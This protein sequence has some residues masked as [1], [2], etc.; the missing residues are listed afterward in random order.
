MLSVF[1]PC[2]EQSHASVTYTNAVAFGYAGYGNKPIAIPLILSVHLSFQLSEEGEESTLTTRHSFIQM[3]KL[4][5]VRGRITYISS[6]AKQEHLYAVYETTDRN[7]WTELARCSQQEFKK[8][9]VDGKCIEARELIIALPESLYEQGMP[10]MLLKSFTDKFKEKYGV[11][12]VAALHH[13]KRMTNFHI[14]LIFSERQLLAE[15][16]IKTA[17]RNMFYDEHGNH[18]RTKKEILDEE[19]NIRKRCKI[20]KKGEVYEKKLFTSKNTRFKQEDFLDEVKLFYTRMIN[21]WVT[22]EKDRLT[23]FDRNG[24]YLA[25]KKIGKNNPKAEQIEKDNRL[26]MDWN[27]EVD[28]AIISEV[29]MEDILQIKKEHITEPIKRSIE[30]YGNRPQRLALILNMAITELV[31]LISKVLEAARTIKNKIMNKD[32]PK[33]DNKDILSYIVI[34]N[35]DNIPIMEE[36]ANVDDIKSTQEES[37][38]EVIVT[39]P[40][41][42]ITHQKIPDKPVMTPEAAAYPKLKKIKAEL[43]NQNSL[44]FQAEQQRGNLEIELSDLKGLAKITR[45][46]ELQRKIDEKTDYINRLKIGLSNM[47]RNNGF[48]NMNEFYLSY[49]ETKSAYAEYQQKVE[50]WNKSSDHLEIVFDEAETIYEK[51]DKLKKDTTQSQQYSY[52]QKKDRT[53]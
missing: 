25:T 52:K 37:I 11:E 3:T 53:R 27:R 29:P 21:R 40:D 8:S 32:I 4:S 10:D 12:C 26:R 13:N 2:R 41:K 20:I 38:K 43:D 50:D 19:G 31:L 49:K 7:Y 42:T 34:D 9:G 39:E 16:V 22:D 28:R 23:V 1:R 30:L 15:P 51:L 45:K 44:I 24:P 14:H 47:V 33:A 17:T 6:H 5:N 46:A 35:T 48:E 36:T 18:V